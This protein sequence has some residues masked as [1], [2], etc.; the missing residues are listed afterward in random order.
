MVLHLID[1]LNQKYT[2]TVDIVSSRERS[3]VS[4]TTSL[5]MAIV[6]TLQEIYVI[7]NFWLG[8]LISRVLI[9]YGGRLVLVISQSVFQ[10]M[11]MLRKSCN[12]LK[13]FLSMSQKRNI[14]LYI[15]KF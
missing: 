6:H 3:S 8:Y 2:F 4:I 1:V 15:F 12:I 11:S 13:V 7:L 10:K 9:S 14:L 5:H